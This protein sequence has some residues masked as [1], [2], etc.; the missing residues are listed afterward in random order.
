MRK[1]PTFWAM[2]LMISL[3]NGGPVWSNIT[4]VNYPTPMPVGTS[5]SGVIT[6]LDPVNLL[7]Q[8]RDN[9]NMIQSVIVD[10]HIEIR[11]N[12]SPVSFNNLSIGDT[13]TVRSIS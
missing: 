2:V 9:G 1:K 12:G 3:A 13:I 10:S 6:N 4:P 11:R 8:L 7:V 5:L